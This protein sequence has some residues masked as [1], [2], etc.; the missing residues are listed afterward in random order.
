VPLSCRNAA[1]DNRRCARNY[2]VEGFIRVVMVFASSPQ[3]L[4]EVTAAVH[5]Y[6][7][8]VIISLS[9][10]VT[11]FILTICIKQRL[12]AAPTCHATLLLAF[13]CIK[14]TIGVALST[15]FWPKCPP[16]CACFD[17]P[18]PIYNV[19]CFLVALRWLVAGY[20]KYAS[21]MVWPNL[22]CT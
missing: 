4:D 8:V 2:I 20:N 15:V 19:V 10:T 17:M 14:L 13:G 6:N 5:L 11:L 21:V 18:L 1:A 22:G 3:C 9:L 12:Q 7:L 16:D